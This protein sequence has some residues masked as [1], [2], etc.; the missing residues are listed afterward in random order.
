IRRP[1]LE[2]ASMASVL[3]IATSLHAWPYEATLL[4]PAVFFAMANAT[5][6]W[7]TRAI[8]ASYVVAALAL[9]LPHAGH[10]LALL[11]IGGLMCWLWYGYRPALGDAVPARPV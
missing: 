8:V 3:G 11:A 4:L 7:R 5:E 6:P 1:L 2:A 10:A 9:S